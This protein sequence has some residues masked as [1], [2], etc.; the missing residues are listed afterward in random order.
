MK[1]LVNFVEFIQLLWCYNSFFFE[2]NLGS[3]TIKLSCGNNVDLKYA[4]HL[5]IYP[6]KWVYHYCYSTFIDSVLTNFYLE[7]KPFG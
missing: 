2:V 1:V 5:K 3:A 6:A 4:D 7:N